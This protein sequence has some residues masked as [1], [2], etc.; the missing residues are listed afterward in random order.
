MTTPRYMS[1]EAVVTASIGPNKVF[2]DNNRN[3][4]YEYDEPGLEGVL[5]VLYDSE[6]NQVS[7]GTTNSAGQY[8]F[9]EL[10]PGSYR[11]AIV[12]I[13]Y[14]DDQGFQFSPVM[15]G[16]NQMSSNEVPPYFNSSPRITLGARENDI[17]LL[18]GMYDPA[19]RLDET[20]NGIHAILL[21]CAVVAAGALAI[22]LFNKK[23][24][25]VNPLETSQTDTDVSSDSSVSSTSSQPAG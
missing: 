25:R 10:E 4:I 5:V 23:Y 19:L 1:E 7:V 9:S 11:I 15:A 2:Y 3:G 14:L 8:S 21:A 18:A 16:G 6:D 12:P 24:V 22:Y 17:T 13:L 20:G